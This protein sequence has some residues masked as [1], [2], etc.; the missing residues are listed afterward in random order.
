MIFWF[1]HCCCCCLGFRDKSTLEVIGILSGFQ[2]EKTRQLLKSFGF[3]SEFQADKLDGFGS[4]SNF[5]LNINWRKP[6]G[7]GSRSLF[8]FIEL[9]CF[10]RVGVKLLQDWT[11]RDS[12]TSLV[13]KMR[14]CCFGSP[15]IFI[16][17]NVRKM[18][19]RMGECF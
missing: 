12:I 4:H 18:P 11:H 2:L 13:A 14:V 15:T 10:H 16:V 5:F 7:F 8:S 17:T 19:I 9:R 3:L 6:D 1:C